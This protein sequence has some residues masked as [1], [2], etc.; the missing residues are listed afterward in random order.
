MPAATGGDEHDPDAR[1][2][3]EAQVRGVRPAA[4]LS[5]EQGEAIIEV[6]AWLADHPL[7]AATRSG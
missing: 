3:F 7:T 6:P 4:G 2:T 5:K 1:V